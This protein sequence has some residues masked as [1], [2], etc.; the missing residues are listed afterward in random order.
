MT[1]DFDLDPELER[2]LRNLAGGYEPETPARIRRFADDVAAGRAVEASSGALV[3]ERVRRPA[4][5]PRPGKTAL[6]LAAVAVVVA[7][8]VAGLVALRPNAATSSAGPQAPAQWSGLSW[9]D[10]TATAIPPS[11]VSGDTPMTV[12]YW[13][14][15]YYANPAT[16]L[17]SSP[18]GATWH[19][20][21]GAP[22]AFAVAATDDLLFVVDGS[23]TPLSYTTDG[24]TWRTAGLRS[25]E[26]PGVSS[27]AATPSA[28]VAVVP[29]KSAASP[30]TVSV[31]YRSTDG[32]TWTKSEVPADMAAAIQVGVVGGRAGFLAQGN[33]PEPSSIEE[34]NNGGYSWSGDWGFWYSRDGS[35]WRQTSVPDN[36]GTTISFVA[37]VNPWPQLQRG[38]L[39]DW[40]EAHGRGYHSIDDLTWTPDRESASLSGEP[41][42]VTS[43]GSR[44][45]AQTTG[46]TFY[47]SPGDGTWRHLVNAGAAVP[48]GGRS[49]VLPAGVLYVAGGHVFFGT[50]IQ[51]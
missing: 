36:I 18:D 45:L 25:G 11:W 37:N 26:C 46:P 23:C 21:E 1:R 22:G 15:T 47:V 33:V 24:Q 5:I 6:A 2:R 12:V 28:V 35:S 27:L 3:M 48:D 39:G 51:G 13:H 34:N 38:S 42:R 50:P 7:V 8:S 16:L 30:L 20:V 4:L 14:G 19:R 9:R 44:I 29:E 31:P 17:W 43:D 40:L 10:V 49:W 32:A 41:L